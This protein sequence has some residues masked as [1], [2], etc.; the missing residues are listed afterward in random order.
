M[1]P[2]F[3]KITVPASGD[4]TNN[5]P[6]NCV[7]VYSATGTVTLKFNNGDAIP[8]RSG[9]VFELPLPLL[10]E[11]FSVQTS[12]ASAA[13]IIYGLGSFGGGGTADLSG[14][15]LQ[16]DAADPNA[17]GVYPTDRQT[18]AFFWSRTVKALWTW[19]V[20]DQQWE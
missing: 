1:K 13:T 5:T 4:W 18:T 16:G 11:K 6:A 3:S 10:W 2:F 8:V 20:T 17:E 9:D 7:K 19:N 15:L 14:Q 12:T